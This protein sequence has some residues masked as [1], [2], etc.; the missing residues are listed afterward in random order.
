[1]RRA[2]WVVGLALVVAGC[3]TLERLD[4]S[5][6]ST[7][8]GRERVVAGSLDVTS[9]STLRV[10]GELGMRGTVGAY[11]DEQG[12]GMEIKSQT[13]GGQR[14]RVLLRT[15]GEGKTRARL[16][17]EGV[18]DDGVGYSLLAGID[19]ALGR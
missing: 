11:A 15:A 18:A 3:E 4:L 12:E 17:W 14:F 9:R 6:R 5:F 10:L 19:A 13:P 8:S 16:V 2:R 1:M 7:T